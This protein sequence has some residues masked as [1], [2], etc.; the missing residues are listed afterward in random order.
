MHAP[1]LRLYRGTVTHRRFEHPAYRFGYRVFSLLLDIDRVAQAAA[2]HRLLSHNRFN[3]FSIHDRDH[4]PKDG[5]AWRP[6]LDAVLRAPDIDLE[7]G[8][9]FLL[10]YPRVL[11]Y[12][13]NPLS[14]WYCHHADGSLR[15][16][17]C[18]VRNTFGDWHGYLLHRDGD[19]LAWPLRHA[20]AKVFHVSPFLPVS[21]EYRFRFSEPAAEVA[22]TVAYYRNVGAA[23][24]LIAVQRGQRLPATDAALLRCALQIPLMTVKVIGAIHWQALKIWLRGARYHRRPEPPTTEISR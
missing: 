22:L 2:S 21:G 11:G 12:V 9:V 1:A 6:W 7:G 19:A 17:L 3:L 18:E 5:S 8:R 10:C 4:G 14:I 20:A 24:T 15:A 13:F 16:V 23:P